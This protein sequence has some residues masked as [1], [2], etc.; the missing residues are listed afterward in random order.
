ML[1]S[2]FMDLSKITYISSVCSTDKTVVSIFSQIINELC[3][4]SYSFH[5]HHV[6]QWHH[7]ES[8]FSKYDQPNWLFYIGYYLEVSSS[9]IYIQELL[10]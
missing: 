10:H 7:E 1:I 2:R 6:L 5:F 9:L 4:S 8:F 3:S